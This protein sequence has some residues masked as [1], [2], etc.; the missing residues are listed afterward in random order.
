MAYHVIVHFQGQTYRFEATES[1]TILEAADQA[2][3]DL[4]LPSSCRAGVCTTCAA[5][6]IAGS[7]DQSEALGVAPDLKAQGYTLLCVA[8]ALSDL[9]VEA[10]KED[11]VYALQFGTGS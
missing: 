4:D 9:E 10:G 2:Q 8:R 5:R 11:E 7:V 6:L 3:V 1:Q